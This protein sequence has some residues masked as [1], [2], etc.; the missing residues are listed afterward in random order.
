MAAYDATY[1]LC[2]Y[3]EEAFLLMESFA[4]SNPDYYVKVEFSEE[5]FKFYNL[6]SKIDQIDEKFSELAMRAM[7][8]RVR[9]SP[10]LRNYL[11]EHGHFHDVDKSILR[12]K[13][14]NM[15]YDGLAKLYDHERVQILFDEILA[16][17]RAMR[18]HEKSHPIGF[19]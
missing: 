3:S 14:T 2:G 1:V 10:I 19:T 7:R 17:T 6:L 4:L 5:V 12:T 13:A 11:R 18:Y 8:I 15:R 9:A 16:P